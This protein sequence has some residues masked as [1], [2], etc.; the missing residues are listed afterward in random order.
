METPMLPSQPEIRD[1]VLDAAERL[2]EH[3]GYRKTTVEEIAQEA[4]IGK[5]SVYLHFASKEDL[6]LCWLKRLHGHILGDLVA[7]TESDAPFAQ[8]LEAV[9]TQRV[10]LRFDVFT[11]HRRSMDEAMTTLREIVHER[12][13]EFHCQEATLFS[14]L[15]R[16]GVEA[17]EFIEDSPFETAISMVIAT[18]SLLPYSLKPIQLGDRD[19]VL[20]KT[21]SLAR[22]LVRAVTPK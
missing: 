22:L 7:I 4:K 10:M 13:E 1:A 8:R 5:G 14:E 16:K 12:R 9:L 18:N 6:G 21:T 19:T 11:R 3:F 20:A 2:F 15:I 17:G